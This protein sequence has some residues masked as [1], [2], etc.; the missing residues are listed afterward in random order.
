MRLEDS[1]PNVGPSSIQQIPKKYH[2]PR[3]TLEVIAVAVVLAEAVNREH[4]VVI[5]GAQDSEDV[6]VV[7]PFLSPAVDLEYLART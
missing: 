3:D 1:A 2:G 4:A 7:E 5:C 6:L